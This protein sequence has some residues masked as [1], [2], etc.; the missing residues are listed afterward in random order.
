[1]IDLDEIRR[2]SR[3]RLD[4][5]GRFHHADEPVEHAGIH[6]ALC[7]GLSVRSDGAVIVRIGPQWCH[8]TAE[9]TPQFVVSMR[10]VDSDL[11]HPGSWELTLLNG[12]TETLDPSTLFHVG[13]VDLYCRTGGGRIVTRFLRDAYHRL[14]EHL[15]ESPDGQGMAL[16]VGDGCVII[17]RVEKRPQH[18]GISG[19]S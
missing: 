5:E 16:G 7:R 9:E 8:V 1:M 12:E 4:R 14:A 6:R 3:I 11:P 2:N 18:P 10:S 17:R 19:A 13:D 15:L